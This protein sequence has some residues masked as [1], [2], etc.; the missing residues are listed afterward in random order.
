[1]QIAGNLFAGSCC[2]DLAFGAP[3]QEHHVPGDGTGDD[4]EDS[5]VDEGQH[6]T[7]VEVTYAVGQR[8]A[9]AGDT[10]DDAGAGTPRGAEAQADAQYRG[11]RPDR[12]ERLR[13]RERVPRAVGPTVAQHE[14][15]RDRELRSQ[16]WRLK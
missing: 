1:M 13:A 11:Q 5:C 7:S 2:G 3:E 10:Q 9:Q 16:H 6:A 15:R 12:A 14:R 8:G 4:V